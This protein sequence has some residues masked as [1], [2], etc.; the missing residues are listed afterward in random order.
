M[1]D[2][3]RVV[4]FVCKFPFIVDEP[5]SLGLSDVRA[6]PRLRVIMFLIF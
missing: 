4:S 2:Y 5:I 6:A 3:Q 1:F